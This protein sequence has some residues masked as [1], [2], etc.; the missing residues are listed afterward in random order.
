MAREPGYVTVVKLLLWLALLLATAGLVF[1]SLELAGADPIGITPVGWRATVL[2]AIQVAFAGVLVY[3]VSKR[4]AWA[5]F[6][7]VG[8]AAWQVGLVIGRFVEGDGNLQLLQLVWGYMAYLLVVNRGDG[9]FVE[10]V[11]PASP[12]GASPTP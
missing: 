11:A 7:A 3:A 2:S 9:W 5:R 10:D 12:D 1:G 8:F 4:R 6:G